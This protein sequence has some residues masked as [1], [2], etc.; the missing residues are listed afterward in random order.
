MVFRII[1]YILLNAQNMYDKQ[2]LDCLDCFIKLNVSAYLG[3]I[4]ILCL[5]IGYAV[6]ITIIM[7]VP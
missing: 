7:T 3:M 2:L 5:Y 1:L 6:Q 4:L